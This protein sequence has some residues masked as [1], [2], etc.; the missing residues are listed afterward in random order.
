MSTKFS[1]DFGNQWVCSLITF[2]TFFSQG[3]MGQSMEKLGSSRSPMEE[4]GK[5]AL[6]VFINLNLG[7]RGGPTLGRIGKSPVHQQS[8]ECGSAAPQVRQCCTA[9]VPLSRCGTAAP[10]KTAR[11]RVEYRLSW[12]RN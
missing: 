2:R 9:A 8:P 11:I 10:S 1:L 3:L 6:S 5:G 12:L 4:R 7:G